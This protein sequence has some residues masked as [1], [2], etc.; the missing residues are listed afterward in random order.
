MPVTA[1]NRDTIRTY[2]MRSDEGIGETFVSPEKATAVTVSN[3][4][5]NRINCASPIQD[6][7]WS[8]EKPVDV[9]PEGNNVFVKM[10][11]KRVGDVESRTT[12]PI[13]LHIVC[14]DQVYTLIL[15]PR[16]MD[17]QTVRLGNP[18]L[19]AANATLKEWGGLALE[20][21][22]KK[23]TLAVFRDELPASF[24][25]GE[26]PDDR[27]LQRFSGN[28]AIRGV[29]RVT[30]PGLGLAA[31]EFSVTSLMPSVTLDERDFLNTDF[32]RDI[33]A[34]TVEPLLLEG[35]R[36]TARVILIERSVGDGG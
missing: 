10:K 16:E 11:V 26:I 21:K 24:Q 6:A 19:K 13:D 35:S 8:T 1:R 14:A 28:L 30:A 2:P 3:R 27:R 33:V 34:I 25:R 23:L 15:H 36:K 22:V 18:T 4:D 5:V 32:S 17:A 9:T 7:F 31:I 20:D 12:V 29:Q